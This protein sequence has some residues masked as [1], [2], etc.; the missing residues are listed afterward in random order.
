M[1]GLRA[2]RRRGRRTLLRERCIRSRCS[3][4]AMLPLAQS[5]RAVAWRAPICCARAR[6]TCLRAVRRRV[7]LFCS[8]A[9]IRGDTR[10]RFKLRRFPI[11]FASK[12]YSNKNSNININSII[13]I[14]KITFEC[15]QMKRYAIASSN[16][17]SLQVYCCRTQLPRYKHGSR[18]DIAY[19]C[20]KGM[21]F[22]SQL[23]T[24]YTVYGEA[25]TY[26]HLSPSYNN[27]RRP[28]VTR[29]LLPSHSTPAST[30]A[31]RHAAVAQLLARCGATRGCR[32]A[33]SNHLLSLFQISKYTKPVVYQYFHSRQLLLINI[34]QC[35]RV[36]T[37]NFNVVIDIAY[38]AFSCSAC[39]R[40][41]A[42]DCLTLPWSLCTPRRAEA[43]A[44]GPT[45]PSVSPPSCAPQHAPRAPRRGR[46][47]SVLIIP[48]RA[49]AAP[50]AATVLRHASRRWLQTGDRVP[51]Q[52]HVRLSNRAPRRNA[53]ARAQTGAAV[54]VPH[55]RSRRKQSG[56]ALRHGR[57][58]L[59]LDLFARALPAA[60]GCG[61]LDARSSGDGTTVWQFLTPIFFLLETLVRCNGR[62]LHPVLTPLFMTRLCTV[63]IMK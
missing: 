47:R 12:V 19:A 58:G 61:P 33:W 49:R 56:A 43:R 13:I 17:D 10:P 37:D 14:H 8:A 15:T 29:L 3:R 40:R 42:S 31:A 1:S 39:P 4:F 11:L 24:L 35:I 20:K 26:L 50:K 34:F 45:S 53:A 9:L 28:C 51:G 25:K 27:N 6:A 46:A 32:M 59:S 41:R 21:Q 16:F 44:S 22:A 7:S 38:L 23:S 5:L 62:K 63:D 30:S 36:I 54:R 48:L 55:G 2:Q 57:V 18:S 52:E 60:V